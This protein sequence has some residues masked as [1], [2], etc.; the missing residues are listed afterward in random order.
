MDLRNNGGGSL[1]EAT[2]LTG[3]FIDQGPVVQ[4]KNSTGRISTE[5][6]TEPGMAWSGPMA[7]LVNRYS[8]SASEI[9]AA[10]IQDYGRGVV[11]GEPTF[12]KGTVQSLLDLDDYALFQPCVV[13]PFVALP[14]S[15][16]MADTDFDGDSDLIDFANLQQAFTGSGR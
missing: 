14:P 11:I 9:F 3:L 7:V 4:V 12:G 15:C 8:A 13:G 10:A 2:T 16:D 6:D 5:A 1:L